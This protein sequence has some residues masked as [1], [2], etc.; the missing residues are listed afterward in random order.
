MDTER[1][2]RWIIRWQTQDSKLDPWRSEAE[3][4]TYR[5]RELPTILHFYKWAGKK[6]YVSLKLEGQSGVQTRDPRLSKQAALTTAP[7]PT[8]H[9]FD[10][11]VH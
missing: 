1:M 7:G 3:H 2:V 5:S 9:P 11:V 10:I 8:C 4:A 6:H